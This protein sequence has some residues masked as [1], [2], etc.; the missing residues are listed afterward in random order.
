MSSIKAY[1][2]HWW[3]VLLSRQNNKLWGGHTTN[4]F[5]R[6]KLQWVSGIEIRR[7]S[8][9]KNWRTTSEVYLMLCVQAQTQTRNAFDSCIK[10]NFL[11]PN[12]NAF[13]NK[14]LTYMKI[15]F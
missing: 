4:T 13:I 10:H 8:E 7:W 1:K 15:A 3:S 9:T 12:L 5:T 6:C 2:E 11:K 14:V